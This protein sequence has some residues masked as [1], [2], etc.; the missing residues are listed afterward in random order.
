MPPAG[1]PPGGLDR[2]F[3]MGQ[4]NMESVGPDSSINFQGAA[5]D[6]TNGNIM[7]AG[8][9]DYVGL[10]TDGIFGTPIEGAVLPASSNL[11]VQVAHN[12]FDA[13]W[14]LMDGVNALFLCNADLS[15]V[16]TITPPAAVSRD[17]VVSYNGR[18]LVANFNLSLP[19]RQI[20]FSDDNGVT[21]NEDPGIDTGQDSAGRAIYTNDAQSVV[22]MI[23]AGGPN[24]AF[25]TDAL[26]AAG[27]WQLRAA[28]NAGV[29]MNDASISDD[30]N[31]I[32]VVSQNGGVATDAGVIP[33]AQNFW[34]SSG[35]FGSSIEICQWVEQ[36][37]GFILVSNIGPFCGFVDAADK[38]RVVP[39][40]WLGEGM[41]MV[42][43]ASTSD[44]EQMI[45]PGSTNLCA[46]TLRN[47]GQTGFN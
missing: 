29:S 12:Y 32:C 31:H 10:I 40:N 35:S 6:P 21:W 11:F 33:P 14:L 38:T 24:F 46:M 19:D 17:G 26:G 43:R 47:I 41:A 7:V 42:D 2:R 15:A 34:Q 5:R 28:G 25:S 36:M 18:I 44:G 1:A 23:Y 3:I 22:V 39:G 13:G 9:N 20:A 30:G 8:N 45:I 16:A 37:N 4:K 27:T